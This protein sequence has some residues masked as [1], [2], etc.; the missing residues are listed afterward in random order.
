MSELVLFSGEDYFAAHCPDSDIIQAKVDIF[1]Q[2]GIWEE[3]VRGMADLT[4]KYD[5]LTISAAD[6]QQHFSNCFA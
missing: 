1:L 5:P 4:V 6:A 3:V 2:S